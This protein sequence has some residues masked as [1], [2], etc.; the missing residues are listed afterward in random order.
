MLFR[1]WDLIG[2]GGKIVQN[3]SV[4]MAQTQAQAVVFAT[5][6]PAD[7]PVPKIRSWSIRKTTSG[8]VAILTGIVTAVSR[9]GFTLTL[10]TAPDTDEYFLDYTAAT[11]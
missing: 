6:F 2:A 3:G 5:E 4:Q 11:A 7:Q 8:E 9:A 1:S 10:N